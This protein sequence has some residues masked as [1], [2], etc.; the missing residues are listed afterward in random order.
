MMTQLGNAMCPETG[1]IS[2]KGSIGTNLFIS[3]KYDYTTD[4]WWSQYDENYL[5]VLQVS[6]VFSIDK[7]TDGELEYPYEAKYSQFS[8]FVYLDRNDTVN[9]TIGNSLIT[10][11][12]ILDDLEV[13]AHNRLRVFDMTTLSF[14]KGDI[15]NLIDSAVI[16]NTIENARTETGV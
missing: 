15:Y 7:F 16:V 12:E 6:E 9:G 1:D 4:E 3:P 8:R 11:H 2:Y 10:V 5:K 14:V 13:V